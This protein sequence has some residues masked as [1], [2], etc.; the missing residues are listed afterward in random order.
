MDPRER[1]APS[2]GH[3]VGNSERS[4]YEA[5][6]RFQ[7]IR[8]T[9]LELDRSFVVFERM[10]KWYWTNAAPLNAANHMV[11][12]HT[13]EEAHRKLNMGPWGWPRNATYY[14][15]HCLYERI[16]YQR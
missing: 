6:M 12:A 8:D 15:F 1:S 13:K 16:P 2:G 3:P 5:G 7:R 4:A 11:F 14:E 10:K 9:E